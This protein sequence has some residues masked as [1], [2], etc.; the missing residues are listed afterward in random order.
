MSVVFTIF[1]MLGGLAFFL[2][3]MNLLSTSLERIS[4]KKL[5]SFLEKA[6]SNIWKGILIGIV[7]TI[8]IQSSS[9]TTVIV[10]GLVNAGV[11]KLKKSIPI[12]MGANIGTTVTAQILSL[13]QLSSANFL[14]QFI[15]PENFAPIISL[16][17]IIIIMVAKKKSK[18]TL[19]EM[20]L[21]FGILFAGMLTMVDAS[22]SFSELPV[23]GEIFTTL[24]NPI[25]GILA[26]AIITAIIQ[27]SAASIG[28]LQALATTGAISCSTAFPIIMGQNI[29]TCIT[30]ILSS[31]G[32]NK[33]AKRAA[34]IHLIFNLLGT[35]IFVIVI[36]A[37][38]YIIGLPFWNDAISMNGIANFHA[39]FNIGATIVLL[40]FINIIEKLSLILVRDKKEESEFD[41]YL[42][43]LR[44]LDK[45]FLD[46]PSIALSKC[47]DLL[48]KMEVHSKANLINSIELVNNFN[49][50]SFEKLK[51]R[52]K[53][54]NL[55]EDNL[56]NYLI[57]LT[58]FKMTDS[59]S[60]RLTYY[61]KLV[62]E[63]E[64][65]G[66][67]SKN[68]AEAAEQLFENKTTF[69]KYAMDELNILAEA[70]KEITSETFEAFEK[71]NSEQIADIEALE[72]RIDQLQEELKYRH[73]E[74]F[75]SGICNAEYAYIYIETLNDLERIADHCTN[76]GMYIMEYNSI[77]EHIT[78]HEYMQKLYDMKNP[79][80]DEYLVRLNNYKKRFSL[81]MK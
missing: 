15:K 69:S 23:F 64:R 38:Q 11:L 17:G 45:R 53:I 56:N 7:I 40:P 70:V 77:N 14:L 21:G 37:I 34:A 39:I 27:S 61:L 26:G 75:K 13:N 36:Y 67:Y 80:Y 43:E 63:F 73:I 50:D 6:T 20:L 9:A 29:G 74:R 41:N 10:V 12:I 3:G 57:Q 44:I 81:E 42:E 62:T 46:T 65:I 54:I 47:E 49:N 71:N 19:G 16:I 72:E 31:I 48:V 30:S 55:M 25:L 51:E 35:T 22:S 5:E 32:A 78:K 28:I 60:K 66:D 2:Y 8:A 52:E 79:K 76:V 4:G 1:S 33:N 59:E 58:S 24:E 18:K 68:I